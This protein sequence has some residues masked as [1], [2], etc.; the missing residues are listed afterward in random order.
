MPL[1]FPFD[2]KNPDYIMVFEWRL[3]RLKRIRENPDCL[4]VMKQFYRDNP[5]QFIIDWGVTFDPRNVDVGL[6]AMIPFILFEKQEEWINWIVERWHNREPG[7]TEKSRD[8]GVSWLS[9]S[10]SATLCLFY[11]NIAIGFGSRKEEYVDRMGDPKSLF[12][13][14]R[15]FLSS[16]P[17]EFR[18]GWDEKKH[19]FHMRTKI[20]ETGSTLTGEAGRSI[21]RG[22]RL[23]LAFLDESSHIEYAEEIEASLSQTT[24]C[25]QDIS[26]PC[27]TNNPFY[28]KVS[29]GKI[30][31]FTF[32]WRDDP[33]KDGTWYAR[34]QNN[35]DPIVLAQEVDLDYFGSVDGIVIPSEWVNAAIDLHKILEYPITGIRKLGFDVAD[36]GKDLNACCGRYGILLEKL[37]SWSGKNSDI[38]AS[39]ER[40]FSICDVDSYDQVSYD[41]DGLGA[42][43]KGDARKI[44]E[45]RKFKI[46]F[47][48]HRGSGEVTE[49][50]KD[51]YGDITGR[52]GRTNEDYF[53]NFKAQ[54][55]WSIRQR[56]HNAFKIR[57][58]I[59][60]NIGHDYHQAE[61]ALNLKIQ[62]TISIDSQIKDYRQLIIELSQPTFSVT[63]AGKIIINKKPDGAR[64]P[65]LADAA[66][67]AFAPI[68]SLGSITNLT[69]SQLRI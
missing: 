11:E 48:A 32:H 28:R 14:I 56:F 68:K 9:T 64:S 27:G 6:P 66:V 8:M 54:C 15:K 25:R 22:D 57:S 40:V 7:V 55:W 52:K 39:V 31:K 41:A 69:L 47:I 21:G 12:Y 44:N 26:T 5:A 35:L 1:P 19:A 60:Q 3:E 53:E 63:K 10:L 65:N 20:P 36:E 46:E 58:Y 51:P 17:I 61:Q 45:Q 23:S 62:D 24:N 67:I 38:A 59:N 34:M 42:G 43:V 49:P 4:P 33:R 16:L 29:E 50:T 13:K 2:F 37:Y 18:G 30:D